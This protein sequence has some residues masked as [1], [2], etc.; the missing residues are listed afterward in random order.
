MATFEKSRDFLYPAH[1]KLSEQ[2]FEVPNSRAPGY[3]GIL[4]NSGFDLFTYTSPGARKNLLEVFQSGLDLSPNG[5]CLGHR[6]IVSLSPQVIY[7]PQFVWQT[8]RE[9]DVRRQ[10]VGSAFHFLRENGRIGGGDLPTVGIWSYNRPEWQIIDLAVQAY[11]G[12]TVSLY[13]SFGPDSV[14]YIC[15]H[16]EISII[17][18]IPSHFPAL[19]S[20][21]RKLKFL[22]A[23]VCI[24]DPLLVDIPK[25]HPNPIDILRTWASQLGLEFFTLAEF[26]TLGSQHH[27]NPIQADSEQIYSICYTSGTTGN[28]K[29]AILTHG[30]CAITAAGGPCGTPYIRNNVFLSILPLAH[31]FERVKELIMLN[32]GAAIG[33]LTA[34]DPTRI[35]EDIQILQPAEI[36]LVP[37]IMNRFHQLIRERTGVDKS[38]LKAKLMQR[39]VSD[40]LALIRPKDLVIP[41]HPIWDRLIFNKIRNVFGGKL[42]MISTG[43]SPIVPEVLKF[44]R[45]AIGCHVYEGYGLTETFAGVAKTVFNDFDSGG[46]VGTIQPFVEVKLKDVP[47]LEYMTSDKPQP[48]GEILCRG[49]NT[50]TRKNGYY[51]DPK[52]TE[53]AVDEGGWFHTG[54][55][56]EIDPCG[57]LKIIDRVKNLIKLSQGEYVGLENVE[58]AYSS[59]PVV[60]QIYVHGDSLRDYLVGIIVPEPSFLSR[61]GVSS[62][63]KDESLNEA[64]VTSLL[65]SELD[66]HAVKIGL[67]GFEKIRRV[68]VTLEPFTVE[69]GML[70]PTFKLRRRDAYAKYKHIIDK[71]YIDK[72]EGSTKSKM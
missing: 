26:E 37:R 69:N 7:S 10:N 63:A 68:Y 11:A 4:R 3:T 34:G 24:E 14:E 31:C 46:T 6:P 15:N 55:V 70:T 35:I 28:P 57:R 51:K 48:R 44:F 41:P 56:G 54:D 27:I 30:Q 36:I 43:A 13:D 52:A 53:A 71:L 64:H 59:C 9:V 60:S 47:E 22:K 58:S 20:I 8:Y 72:T 21:A 39:A 18:S 42:L 29:G 2:T 23:V 50:I 62:K 16:A 5:R 49:I 66:A 1:F 67:R 25:P 17:F 38:E 33:Y 65:L 61:V 19:L 12:V 32:T 40:K 45:A